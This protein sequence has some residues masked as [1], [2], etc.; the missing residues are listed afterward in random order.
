MAWNATTVRRSCRTRVPTN[1]AIP[2]TGPGVE[3]LLTVMVMDPRRSET[4][5]R[6]TPPAW[7]AVSAFVPGSGHLERGVPCQDR[8]AAW[9]EPRPALAVFDGRGSAALSHEGAEAALRALRREIECLED[10]L[11]TTLDED[12]DDGLAALAWQGLAQWLYTVA[13]R[14]QREL[15]DASGRK[16]TDY[17][18]T[19]SLAVVGTRRVGWMAVGDSPIVASRHGILFLPRRIESAEFANQTRFVQ[20]VPGRSPG[21]GGGIIPSDGLDLLAAMSDGAATRLIDLGGHVAADAV[22][23]LG[24]LL[25]SGELDEPVITMM[26]EEAEWDAVTRD[27][28]SVAILAR[29]KEGMPGLRPPAKLEV[30]SHET[31]RRSPEHRAGDAHEFFGAA[32]EDDP[33]RNLSNWFRVICSTVLIVEASPIVVVSVRVVIEWVKFGPS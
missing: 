23:A 11:R 18:F 13:A 30:P 17:E 32:P 33:E 3:D 25:V 12:P 26:L 27:D 22:R 29:R 24:S 7:E 19:L 6:E 1:R 16:P 4:R 9:T 2:G 20:A 5:L 14:V 31:R 8:A 15:A 28:R 10:R 21:L